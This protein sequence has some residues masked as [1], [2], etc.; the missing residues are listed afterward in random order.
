MTVI[1]SDQFGRN[2][3]IWR[4]Y[5]WLRRLNARDPDDQ[6]TQAWADAHKIWEHWEPRYRATSSSVERMFSKARRVFLRLRLPMSPNHAEELVFL[7][8]NQE[9]AQELRE[10]GHIYW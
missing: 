4:D 2:A 6:T 3:D 7:C 8:D 1:E 10:A 9:I 5:L